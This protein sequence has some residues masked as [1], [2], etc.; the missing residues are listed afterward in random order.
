MVREFEETFAD[1]Y[2]SYAVMVNSGSS[3]NLLAISALTNPRYGRLK[4]GDEVIVSALSWPTTIWPLVQHGLVPVFVDIDAETLNI[5]VD[6]ARKAVSEKTR[7]IMPIHV[8]GNPCDMGALVCLC[9]DEDLILVEDCCE[10]LG[11]T[12]DGEPVGA[13]GTIGTFS[14]YFSHHMTTME[15]GACV[16]KSHELNELMRILRAHGWTRDVDD[17]KYRLA[18]PH[19]DPKFL[20]VNAGYNLRATE[21]QAA[22]GLVQMRK[23]AG[24]L[25][26]RRRAAEGLKSVFSSYPDISTQLEKKK[27]RS[28]WFGF[29]VLAGRNILVHELRRYFE[30]NGIETRA[31]LCDMT[32]QPAM[33]LWEHRIPEPCFNAHWAA[34][35]GFSIGCHQD[36]SEEQIEH[37]GKTL[38]AFYG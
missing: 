11:A 29:P 26:A 33:R 21:L 25:E 10:A 37:V 9:L 22:I 6:K 16:T 32:I 31:I 1:P 34:F 38:E 20:F 19:I 36:I 28:S 14:F 3:A 24:F 15:G 4:P 18:Y 2:S 30:E 12:Y 13:F 17:K 27:G 23:L 5:D 8:Y 7:A 35:H